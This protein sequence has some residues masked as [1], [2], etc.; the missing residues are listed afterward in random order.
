MSVTLEEVCI[1]TVMVMGF[2]TLKHNPDAYNSLLLTTVVEASSLPL[3]A[4]SDFLSVRKL[5]FLSLPAA[6]IS[7]VSV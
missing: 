5:C 1:A 7:L 6:V 2:V 4:N 3:S